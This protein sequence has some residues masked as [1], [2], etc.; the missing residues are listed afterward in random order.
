MDV[1]TYQLLTSN[2][3]YLIS[4]ITS[5]PDAPPYL[6]ASKWSVLVEDAKRIGSIFQ[7]D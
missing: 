6:D 1:A 3:I 7:K 2:R 4:Q 5:L